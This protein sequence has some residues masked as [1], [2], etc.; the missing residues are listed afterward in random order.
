[1][2][3]ARNARR[4]Q[5]ASFEP[6]STKGRKLDIVSW[7]LYDFANSAYPTLIV[8]VAYSV[9]FKNIVAGGVENSDF[10]WGISLSAA[11]LITSL[12]APPLSTVADRSGSR[13]RLLL[14]FAGVCVTATLLLSLVK[15]G[16]VLAGMI[17]FII[18]T[19][20]FEGSL[21]FYNA[22]LPE[23]ATPA[24]Q[25]R[26]SGW[27]WGVGYLGGL[28]CLVLV[29]PFLDGGFSPENLPLFRAS[30]A[31]VAIFYAVFTLPL[32]LWL[33]EARTPAPLQANGGAVPSADG[34]GL[35]SNA[36]AAF[37][38]LWETFRVLRRSGGALRFLFAFFLYNDGI[39]TVI[40]F[41]SIYAVSTLGFS[42]G[43][44]L[45]LFIA[46]QISAGAGALALG[47]LADAWGE[48]RTILLT[49]ANWC[50][51]VIAAYFT[52]TKGVFFAVS[53]LAG[54]SLGSCQAASRSLMARFIPPGGATQTYAFYGLCGKMSSV[55]GPLVFGAVSWA[56]GSQR[57][58]ILSILVFFLAGGG[59][60]WS[61][62]EPAEEAEG[63]SPLLP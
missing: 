51:V 21:I 12:L 60:L 7:C 38:T 55:M 33:R 27:G 8:T 23:I 1:M 40:S 59:L 16:M 56:T 37:R 43:E 42:M 32:V 5:G 46:V 34:L 49:L 54:F 31:A 11:M 9:Y 36:A 44:T 45:Q 10:L 30:F 24:N 53:I 52:E 25:G 58:A 6:M 50:I 41:S 18:A 62:R 57:V 47:Y 20:G 4:G 3:T 29:K 63:S 17:L 13:K 61:V 39:V 28:L 35:L 48:R 19:I 14:I 2:A 22:F 15:A 26:I